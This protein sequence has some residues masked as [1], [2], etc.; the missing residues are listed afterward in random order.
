M[1]KTIIFLVSSLLFSALIYQPTLVEVVKLRTFDYFVKTEEPTG[2]IVLLN[3]TESDI[4]NEGGW[5]FPRKRLAKIHIDLLNAGAASVSWVAVFSEPDRF[6]GDANFA[7][8]L[9]YYPSVIA[10]FE[11]DGYKEIPKTEGT[12]ILGDDIGGIIAKGVTQNI[13]SLRDVALQGIVSAPVDVDSLV[14]RMP[15]LMRSPDGWMASFG[16]QLLKSVTGTSTYVI[17]TNANGIQEVRVKQLNPIPTDFDGRV[18]VNWVAPAETSLSEMD[19]EGKVVIVGTTAKGILPQVAT[20]KGLL[21]P[22]QI[23]ASLAE[24]IIHASNKRMPMI[25]SDAR[26]YEILIFILGVLLVFLFINYLGVYLGLTFSG[27][28]IA[29]MG[30]LGFVLIQRGFLVDVTW[31]MVSQF[32]VASATFYL[33]YKEQYKLRQLIKKQFEHYLDPRQVKR[34][35][36][37]PSLLTLGGEKRY[38]TFLFTDVRGFTALSERVTPE[39][40]TYIM[41]KALT[42]QQSAV[43]QCYGM[44]DKYIGDAM[45]AIFGAPLDLENHEDW[46]IKCAK[47]IQVNMEALNLE[48]ESKELPAIQIGIGINS[49]Y[50]IIGNMGSQQRFDY[51]AIG[52][53]VNTAARL[54]SATKEAGTDLLIGQTTKD[55]CSYTLTPLKPMKVKGKEKPLKIYTF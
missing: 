22:H 17:K 51:T 42:A 6:G 12:V 34:L 15:L 54:E 36:E 11:T 3:L 53:A 40:V 43:A 37:D 14:R 49:G 19:V 16:T 28:S 45:M 47:Q 33:N 35:Q 48:F 25:P 1:K 21:Y 13:P 50:A 20:P 27:L 4:Q 2:A 18:W 29:G 5:P 46:A 24:T 9:S 8:A 44:V 26:L 10:M 23:Q 39:E 55:L 32:V 52:D 7:E 30:F 41:N 31:T 38:C